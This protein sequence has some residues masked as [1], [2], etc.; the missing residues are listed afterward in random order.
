M[1]KTWAS[2]IVIQP[3]G[4]QRAKEED[5]GSKWAGPNQSEGISQPRLMTAGSCH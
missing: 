2:P 3:P 4:L 5:E 1:V